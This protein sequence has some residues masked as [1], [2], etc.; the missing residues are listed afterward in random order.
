[1]NFPDTPSIWIFK[2][3]EDGSNR[4]G[5]VFDQQH[6][7][8]YEYDSNAPNYKRIKENDFAVIASKKTILGI[9]RISQIETT[10]ATK[11]IVSCPWCSKRV[12]Y[13]KTKLP[14]YRCNSGHEFNDDV[15]KSVDITRFKAIYGETYCPVPDS[16]DVTRLK[17]FYRKYNQYLSIQQMKPVFTEKYYTDIF[18]C[19][20]NEDYVTL[21]KLSAANSM[22][23]EEEIA[24]YALS[25][26]DERESIVRQLKERR[27]QQK[28]RASLVSRYGTRCMVTGCKLQEILEAAHINPYKGEKDNHPA[29]GL[30]LRAD[31][32]TLFDLNLIGI[33]PGTMSICVHASVK[34]KT[35]RL[36]NNKKLKVSNSAVPDNAALKWRWKMFCEVKGMNI[37]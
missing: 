26:K 20:V 3:S 35:Y 36:L 17:R 19:L 34:D 22:L 5:F 12:E 27:G 7:K 14:R 33:R 37:E 32:H 21:Q 23:V 24:L 30:L 6:T 8:H 16:I 29:N 15:L 2:V 31:I 1:M 11:K 28:F 9:A 13:R 25:E 4:G 10:Q 18:E